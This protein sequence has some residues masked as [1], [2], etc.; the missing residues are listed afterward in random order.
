MTG[1]ILPFPDDSHAETQSLLPW[2]VTGRLQS[3][4]RLRIEAHLAV[5][6]DCQAEERRERRLEAEVAGMPLEVEEGWARMRARLEREPRRRTAAAALAARI[7]AARAGLRRVFLATPGW[8]G[9]ALAGQVALV[10][11]MGFIWPRPAVTPAYHA[12]SAPVV[13][14]AG[15]LVV[16]FRP[17]TREADLRGALRQAHARL[18]G[19]PTAADAYVLRVPASERAGALATLRHRADIV[20]VEPLDTGDPQ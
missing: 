19:G 4:E 13:A 10:V 15:N 1:R 2:F 9:P 17:E 3:D 18:V 8:V 11:M 7:A 20:L 16:I 6:A 5:C 14:E 12:L